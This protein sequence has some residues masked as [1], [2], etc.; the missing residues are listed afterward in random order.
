MSFVE[1]KEEVKC[2]RKKNVV[3]RSINKEAE[4]NKRR[5]KEGSS[6]S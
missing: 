5:V 1:E 3:N 4:G 2:I 6:E